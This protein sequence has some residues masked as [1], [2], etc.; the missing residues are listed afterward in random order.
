MRWIKK[1]CFYHAVLAP[2][3]GQQS[4]WLVSF[5]NRSGYTYYNMF[6]AFWVIN[7]IADCF[8]RQNIKHFM[9]WLVK[10]ILY[11]YFIFIL[12]TFYYLMES[13]P[14]MVMLD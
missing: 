12:T 13:R 4:V 1:S 7:D 2:Q 10:N 5:C 9:T 8:S 3:V 14:S 11:I 6:N